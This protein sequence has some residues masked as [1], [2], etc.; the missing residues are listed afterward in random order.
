MW[1]HRQPDVPAFSALVKPMRNI[2]TGQIS[3]T[4]FLNISIISDRC[5]QCH[6]S[7]CVFFIVHISNICSLSLSVIYSPQ[8][9]GILQWVTSVVLMIPVTHALQWVFRLWF[10]AAQPLVAHSVLA[11]IN[12]P[13]QCI[14]IIVL[15]GSCDL[16][17]CLGFQ[18]VCESALPDSSSPSVTGQSCRRGNSVEKGGSSQQAFEKGFSQQKKW[19]FV[20]TGG[21]YNR[22]ISF[23]VENWVFIEK[24]IKSKIK[25]LGG[26][27]YNKVN[28][29]VNALVIMKY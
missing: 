21:A 27:F 2:V 7:L 18:V 1:E 13:S 6:C 11:Y 25:F 28:Q 8:Q 26:S 15:L 12:F 17:F 22:S 20:H 14:N 9:R 19:V 16:L 23:N 3:F 10:A 29:L 5:Y 24:K 4:S